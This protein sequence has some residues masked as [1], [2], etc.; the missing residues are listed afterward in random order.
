M[1]AL[2]M[3]V[4]V[5]CSWLCVGSGGYPEVMA[6]A[7]KTN[8]AFVGHRSLTNRYLL[9]LLYHHHVEV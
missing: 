9:V 1:T 6:P 2:V 8:A 5:F 4:V 3:N 7:D